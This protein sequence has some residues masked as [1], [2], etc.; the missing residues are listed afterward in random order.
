MELAS[1]RC[2]YTVPKD[3]TPILGLIQDHV[4]GGVLLSIKD[5]FFT[6]DDYQHLVLNAFPEMTKKLRTLPPTILK[7]QVL[8]TGK[9]VISTVILNVLPADA[10][11]LTVKGKA[12]VALKNWESPAA[13]PLMEDLSEAQV[14]IQHGELL[15]GVLD[16]AH[17]G[18]TPFGLIHCCHELYGSRT[19]CDLLSAF[20]R[21]FTTFLQVVCFYA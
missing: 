5:Q 1:A 9:Q 8:W 20:S 4:V 18:A 12:K 19:A 17:F 10:P 3:G 2:N 11:P 15:V 7:P 14:I 6:R 21:L 16:K 13:G